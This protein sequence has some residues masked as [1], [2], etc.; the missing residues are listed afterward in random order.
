MYGCHSQ[1][2]GDQA[3]LSTETIPRAFERSPNP[4]SDSSYLPIS[5]Q[6]LMIPPFDTT[7]LFFFDTPRLGNALGDDDDL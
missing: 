5:A 4:A 2:A 6:E 7:D 1:P 3:K